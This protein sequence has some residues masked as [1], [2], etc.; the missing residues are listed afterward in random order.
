MCNSSLFACLV[1]GSY[2]YDNTNAITRAISKS[3]YRFQRLVAHIKAIPFIAAS[4][5]KHDHEM[6][7]KIINNDLP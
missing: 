1:Q 6:G 4:I 7:D 5:F 3:G 2:T